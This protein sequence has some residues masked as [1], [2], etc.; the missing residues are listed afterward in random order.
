MVSAKWVGRAHVQQHDDMSSW[1]ERVAEA[2][3][4]HTSQASLVTYATVWTLWRRRTFAD[5]EAATVLSALCS[6]ASPAR[7]TGQDR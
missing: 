1:A 6:A 7:S 2:T 4:H 3:V 5:L